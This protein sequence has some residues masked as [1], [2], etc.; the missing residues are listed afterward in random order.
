MLKA[1]C[2]DAVALVALQ[3]NAGNK[4]FVK[5]N[6][7]TANIIVNKILVETPKPYDFQFV[8]NLRF[9]MR[10]N[11]RNHKQRAHVHGLFSSQ[12]R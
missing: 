7:V 1:E 2:T 11:G 6:T 9:G 5:S 10:P 12:L 4:P 3:K 8:T